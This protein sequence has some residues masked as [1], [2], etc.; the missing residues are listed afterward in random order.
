MKFSSS[1]LAVLMISTLMSC[2]Q[3]NSGNQSNTSTVNNPMTGGTG[4]STGHNSN[5]TTSTQTSLS[6]H[7]EL[8]KWFEASSESTKAL[9]TIGSKG[10]FLIE[11]SP[12][13]SG[14]S[15][16]VCLGS[17][18]SIGNCEPVFPNRCYEKKSGKFYLGYPVIANNSVVGCEDQE[19][20]TKAS[21][22]DLK[23]SI[24]G[25]ED[26]ELRSVVKN[27]NYKTQY[28][29]SYARPGYYDVSKVIYIDTDLPS[30]VNPIQ[31]YDSEQLEITYLKSIFVR[32]K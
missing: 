23:S 16:Q 28:T 9:T 4:G 5:G 24:Y 32:A 14:L 17:L 22:I 13:Q 18:V 31:V 10:E 8:K 3:N 7:A 6:A 11:S 2:G 1:V 25:I 21:N 30:F 20:Y 12:I 29:L 27:P 26:L 15:L 19:A